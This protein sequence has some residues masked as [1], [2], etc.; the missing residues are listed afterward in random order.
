MSR[1]SKGAIMR[2]RK[3]ERPGPQYFRLRRTADSPRPPRRALLIDDS[4]I[5]R[6]V[7]G[8]ALALKGPSE[9][10]LT[11]VADLDLGLHL[12]WQGRYDLVLLADTVSSLSPW[13]VYQAVRGAAPATPIVRHAR[14]LEGEAGDG[15]GLDVLVEAVCAALGA[16]AASQP[17]R[18]VRPAGIRPSSASGASASAYAAS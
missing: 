14:Y 13:E 10:R 3:G 4:R 5:D 18:P 6:L 12:L 17:A 7:V 15:D 11:E 8:A 16:T 2:A 1:W 9:L